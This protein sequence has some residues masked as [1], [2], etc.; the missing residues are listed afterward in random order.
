MYESNG[1]Y[2]NSLA[3][4]FVIERGCSV[5]QSRLWTLN[6]LTEVF[7]VVDLVTYLAYLKDIVGNIMAVSFCRRQINCVLR[8]PDD[9]VI[10][11]NETVTMERMIEKLEDTYRKVRSMN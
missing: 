2:E 8:F 9:V 1:R 11:V 5:L 4:S 10:L 3:E 7:F 6:G